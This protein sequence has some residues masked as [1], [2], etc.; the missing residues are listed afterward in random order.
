MVHHIPHAVLLLFQFSES[1]FGA[2]SASP[3]C[4]KVQTVKDEKEKQKS[5]MKAA[6]RE[7]L[8]PG[9]KVGDGFMR[10]PFDLE[11]GTRTSGADC[12]AAPEERPPERPA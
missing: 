8:L 9:L 6:K 11:L 4:A 3:D 2:P 10:H 7:R 5:T 12:R 1:R